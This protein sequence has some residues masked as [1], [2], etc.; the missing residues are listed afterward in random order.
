MAGNP[1]DFSWIEGWEETDR[2][3]THGDRRE[4]ERL[5][6]YWDRKIAVLGSEATIAALD[7]DQISSRD[8]SNRFLISVDPVIERSALIVYGPKFARLL[9]L[10]EQARPE[11]PLLRQ[12]PQ[13]YGEV[14]MQGC[15]Q[16]QRELIPIRLEG[17]VVRYDSKIEQ[18]RIIF[19]PIGIK[20]NSLTCFAFGAFSYRVDEP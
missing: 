15:A 11:L 19:V 3:A 9:S 7:L 4:A 17:K 20:P 12:L 13:R 16:A 6:A 2:D 1:S 8:W 18:Y 10:P 5:M 14:F